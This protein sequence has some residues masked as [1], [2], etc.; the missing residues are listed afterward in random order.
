MVV[1]RQRGPSRGTYRVERDVVVG[2][3]RALEKDLRLTPVHPSMADFCPFLLI[4]PNP[5]LNVVELFRV[6]ECEPRPQPHPSE[7]VRDD[8]HTSSAST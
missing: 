4:A 1:F 7:E 3:A 5:A 8:T 2:E 6:D